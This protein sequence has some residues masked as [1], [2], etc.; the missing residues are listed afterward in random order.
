MMKAISGYFKEIG[1]REARLTL[2][3]WLVN[4][5]AGAGLLWGFHGF[6]VS[7]SGNPLSPKGI[8][9]FWLPTFLNDL[10]INYPGSMA[11]LAIAASALFIVF[12]LLSVF[13]SGGVY[14]LLL[15]L[16]RVSIKRL[17]TLSAEHFTRM[18]KLFFANIA[19][20]IAASIVPGIFFYIHYRKQQPAVEESLLMSFIYGWG[21][22][23]VLFY[24]YSIAV[25]D[26]SRIHA[27]KDER[28]IFASLKR[29]IRSVF[30]HKGYVLIIFIVY[31]VLVAALSFVCSRITGLFKESRPEI[32]VIVIQ[33]VFLFL[34]Y[35]SK[36]LLMRA[37]T[38]IAAE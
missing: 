11:A 2:Y 1:V 24:I 5:L 13:L 16:G 28:G 27:I 35:L 38:Q 19:N 22:L 18:M 33:Q 6:F 9:Y 36:I 14:A 31:L 37:E 10:S 15:H 4:S 21:A 32:V 7:A 8:Y 25:Y 20:F 12:W 23:L 3:A 30:D 26:L 34:R 29:G 17:F